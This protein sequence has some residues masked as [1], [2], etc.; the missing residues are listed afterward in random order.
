MSI[1]R[2]LGP[3]LRGSWMKVNHQKCS[4]ILLWKY[5]AGWSL[6]HVCHDWLF[7]CAVTQGVVTDTCAPNS[8]IYTINHAYVARLPY[9]CS[10][11]FTSY[12]P[13][14]LHMLRDSF[15]CDMC[16]TW[17]TMWWPHTSHVMPHPCIS[18]LI[19]IYHDSQAFLCAV[20][21]GVMTDVCSAALVPAAPPAECCR[22]A[23]CVSVFLLFLFL[24]LISLYLYIRST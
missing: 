5:S 19:R 17:S 16:A 3:S 24:L 10:D 4:W 14:L 9:M 8:S 20:P 2:T 15:T 18:W 22:T 1:F 7:I 12:V 21:H 13:W 23:T 6:I 11:S